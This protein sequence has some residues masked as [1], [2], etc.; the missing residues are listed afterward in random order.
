MALGIKMHP[1]FMWLFMEITM[2]NAHLRKQTPLFKV[3]PLSLVNNTVIHWRK[4]NIYKIKLYSK[5]RN[6]KWQAVRLTIPALF[7]SSLIS[8]VC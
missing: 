2:P 1:M 4:I 8:Q 3:T 5:Q 6:K 7:S